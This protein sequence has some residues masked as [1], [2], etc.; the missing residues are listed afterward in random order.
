M[1]SRPSEGGLTLLALLRQRRWRVP[2]TRGSDLTAPV[3]AVRPRR[4]CRRA[5]HGNGR[6][7][8]SAEPQSG[9]SGR[10]GFIMRRR[11]KVNTRQVFSGAGAGVV[12]SYPPDWRG[13]TD[14]RLN[15][16]LRSARV[17]I[18]RTLIGRR[19]GLVLFC[20]KCCLL[21]VVAGGRVYFW[22][23]CA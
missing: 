20:W 4:G 10:V 8:Y 19:E 6:N 23:R 9:W 12:S 5:S 1:R 16:P 11:K 7:M 21:V 2:R 13:R 18:G 14:C 3:G 15:E 17:L 22:R